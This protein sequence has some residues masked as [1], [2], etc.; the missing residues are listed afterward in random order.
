MN[1]AHDAL[2]S[3]F[4]SSP[5]YLI[6]THGCYDLENDPYVFKVPENTYIFEAQTI[7]DMCMTSVDN[8][9]WNLLQGDN[10]DMFNYY[11]LNPAAEFNKYPGVVHHS[12]DVS[13]GLLFASIP[14]G[15]EFEAA[16]YRKTLQQF[17]LYE[18]GDTMA[19]RDL[20]IGREGK[21]SQSRLVYNG[22]KFYRFEPGQAS[23]IFPKGRESTIMPVLHDTLLRVDAE[24]KPEYMITNESVIDDV[25]VYEGGIDRPRVF[26]VSS[27]A[28]HDVIP[29]AHDNPI[30]K[31]A[32]LREAK[33][34]A[35]EDRLTAIESVQRNAQLKMISLEIYSGMGGPHSEG[36]G[37]HA[38][39]TRMTP[40]RSVKTTEMFAPTCSNPHNYNRHI[41]GD[42]FAR[43]DARDITK[44]V[45]I[46]AKKR[47]NK[48]RHIVKRRKHK[49]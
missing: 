43:I 39:A 3:L 33:R 49:K 26:F 2:A 23:N 19:I 38:E 35:F 45:A 15:E 9:L 24:G 41:S 4:A 36:T 21:L 29:K 48:K 27:C 40:S 42:Y 14:A 28:D 6:S 31:R 32:K 13:G 11:L 25:N 8:P 20:T 22:M 18:P 30:T 7:G 44:R 1:G 16:E 47:T 17:I 10:R 37:L 46:H 34:E 5:F 12:K